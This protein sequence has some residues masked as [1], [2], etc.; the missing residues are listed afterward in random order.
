MPKK[1]RVFSRE[2]KLMVVRRLVAGER[3]SVVARETQVLRKDLYI[4]RDRYR[5]G[6]AEALRGSGRPRKG[7][8]LTAPKRALAGAVAEAGAAGQRI[9]E[10]E[11]KV[12][13]Q[14]VELDF[15]R[16]ALRQLR[17]ARRPSIGPGVTGSTQ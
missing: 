11:R 12:G 7:E 3:M 14:Q 5:S 10:L 6:G 2:F 1:A 8:E 9:A 15:F 16:Q 4:W 17:E 13:Q